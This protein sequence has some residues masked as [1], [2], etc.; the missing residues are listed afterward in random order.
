MQVISGSGLNNDKYKM[1]KFIL[2][3]E[4]LVLLVCFIV[5]RLMVM[6]A[7]IDFQYEVL[8]TYWQYLDAQSLQHHLLRNVWYMHAQ[9]PVFN[10]F[11]GSILQA[12]GQYAEQLFQ[13]VW[14]LITCCNAF[15]LLRI[16][17]SL[18]PFSFLP[19]IIALWYLL[20]PATILYENELLY[21]SFVSMLLLFSVF[22]LQKFLRQRGRLAL[23]GFFLS[24]CLLCLSRSVFHLAWLICIC[25]LPLVWFFKK[26]PFMQVLFG[27]ILSLTAV[28]CFYLK[29]YFVFGIFSLSSWMGINL[30]RTVY[31]GIPSKDSTNISSIL[32]FMPVSY[33]KQF[34][35]AGYR[36]R[37][38]GI[39]DRI[40][41]REMKSDTA[42]NMN[43]VEYIPISKEY[44]RVSL[45]F[46]RVHPAAYLKNVLGAALIFFTPATGYYNVKNNYRKLDVYDKVYSLN[47]SPLLPKHIDRKYLLAVSGFPKFVIYVLVFFH[48]IRRWWRYRDIDLVN[49]YIIFSILFVFICSSLLEYGENMRFRYELEPLFLILVA[50]VCNDLRSNFSNSK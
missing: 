13:V 30:S 34:I 48:H 24:L 46:I 50:W 17:K 43:H 16:V 22:F 6:R 32:P 1:R 9:P 44:L 11:V 26:P 40:L 10:L 4:I 5:S 3:H 49:L 41:L 15:L 29:N 23:A 20:S 19:L 31:L 7:G 45:N 33:Y 42:I 47:L 2:R 38:A 18:S 36:Q 12:G 21:T 25:V 8:F 14:L 37:Y 28:G 27:S 35:P 39:S